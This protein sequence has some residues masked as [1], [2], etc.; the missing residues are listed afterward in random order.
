MWENQPTTTVALVRGSFSGSILVSRGGS[1]LVSG[2]MTTHSE[3]LLNHCRPEELIIISMSDGKTVAK[4][5]SQ[6]SEISEEIRRT[7]F[8]LGYYYTSN[9]L[10]ND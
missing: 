9:A 4:R 2:H 5:Y 10:Q 6:P 3:T 1:I 8:G 7:G